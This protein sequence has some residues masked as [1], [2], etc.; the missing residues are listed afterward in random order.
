MIPKLDPAGGRNILLGKSLEEICRL[1]GTAYLAL[2]EIFGADRRYSL[3]TCLSATA[4]YLLQH[5]TFISVGFDPLHTTMRS[6]K[7]R[8]SQSR[9]TDLMTDLK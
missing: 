7:C 5:G 4:T 6:C 8:S 3:P 1:G 9:N 2:P